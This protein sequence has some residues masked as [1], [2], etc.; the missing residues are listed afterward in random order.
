MK[1]P[2][3]VI[4]TGLAAISRLAAA[5]PQPPSVPAQQAPAKP[6]AELIGDLSNESYRV[7]E[8]ASREIWKLGESAKESLATAA[9]SK[10]PET[11]YRARELLRKIQLHIT[12]DTDP[13]VIVL[14]ERYLKASLTEKGTLLEKMKMKRAW[15]QMLKL[16]ADEKSAEARDKLGEHVQG[17]AMVAA[18]ESIAKGE[19]QAAREFLEMAPADA[20]GLLAL[21]EFHRSHGTLAAEIERANSVKGPK[22]AAWQLALY[23]ASGDLKGAWKAAAAAGELKIAATMAALAGDP[24]PWLLE[25][26][27]NESAVAAAYSE[28]AAKRWL[29]KKVR[30]DDLEPIL[31]TLAMRREYDRVPAMN[32]LFLLGELETVEPAFA[33]AQ[34]LSAFLYLQ[35]QERIPEAMAA[36]GL[37]PEHPDYKAWVEKRLSKLT[38][39]EIEDQHGAS[40]ISEELVCLANLLERKGLHEE[41]FAAFSGPLG[42]L[43]EKDE[44][45]FK[46]LLGDLFGNRRFQNGAPLLAK[47]IGMAWA[48]KK[49]ANWEELVEISLGGED[50]S[51]DATEWWKWLAEIA[52]KDSPED[53]Y[54][55]LVAIFDLG[56]DP[57][58]LRKQW[59]GRVWKA[60]G[61]A[62]EAERGT[63]AARMSAVALFTGDVASSL[64][65][66]DLMSKSA[67]DAVSVDRHFF[68]LTAANRW[69][70]AA[71]LILKQMDLADDGGQFPRAELHAYA[72]AAL[73]KAGREAEAAAHD[74]WADKLALGDAAV[75]IRAG[76]CYA[77][78][79]DYQRAGEWWARAAREANP[80]SE[81]SEFADAM[82][83][84]S[85]ALLNEGRWLECAAVSEMLGKINTISDMRWNEPLKCMHL[86]LQADM[87]RALA[88]LKNDRAG[89]IAILDHAHQLFIKDGSLADFFF[90]SV[91]RMGLVEKHD[92][93]FEESWKAML[94]IVRL[95]PESDNTR[96][97]TAWL[98][99]RAMRRLDEAEELLNKAL[100][101]NPG[102]SAYLDTMAEIQFAKGNR[103]KALEWSRTAVN[104]D[105]DDIQLRRQQERF[106]TEPLPK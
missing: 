51:T 14:V 40:S 5:A 16:Y 88:N 56:P 78:G 11:A 89:S 39:E 28:V 26:K 42:A 58:D 70:D 74:Q 90:P 94:E 84:Y 87:C 49:E 68:H 71:A 6:L 50:T 4:F 60:I 53:R 82:E 21:A 83:S 30:Q 85:E 45:A 37:E 52:P 13:S 75:A 76:N 81:G 105:P 73:R 61:E 19:D 62:P 3:A 67:R 33:K 1:F 106:R 27:D 43:E 10:D 7:R 20:S 2:T 8:D 46:D 72:A 22:G 57:A 86:R 63:L 38:G 97:T 104:S 48:G 17:V 66:W 44:D 32:A 29:G 36:L 24:L 54:K 41:A 93:W 100:S 79:G 25:V 92:E 9:D 55:G 65:A 103:E 23:R 69:N 102:Q 15:R 59:L 64:K 96:N 47:R 91:R 98:A 77:N 35:S 34:P 18:R 95:Y 31:K 101:I 80:D 99:S 12:P